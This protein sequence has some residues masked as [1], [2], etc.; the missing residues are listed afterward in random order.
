MPK[1]NGPEEIIA[2]LR[3]LDVLVAKANPSRQRRGP[4]ASASSLRDELR[5]FLLSS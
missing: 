4:S 5:D 2:K 1:K 3:Q